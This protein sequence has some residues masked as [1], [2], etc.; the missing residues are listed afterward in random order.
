METKQNNIYHNHWSLGR[1]NIKNNLPFFGLRS[2]V[3]EEE[4]GPGGQWDKTTRSRFS[5]GEDD[6]R[7]D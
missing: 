6:L 1:E 3:G 4:I 5:M 2:F 7:G